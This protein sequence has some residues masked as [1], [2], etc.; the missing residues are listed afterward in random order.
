MPWKGSNKCWACV[1]VLISAGKDKYKT[2]IY[3]YI[4]Q[5]RA[6]SFKILPKVRVNLKYILTMRNRDMINLKYLPSQVG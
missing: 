6:Y 2:F 5:E 4:S 3:I 1:L